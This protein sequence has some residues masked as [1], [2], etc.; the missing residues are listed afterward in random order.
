MGY[1]I[2]FYLLLGLFLICTSC[3]T[4]Q[5]QVLFQQKNALSDSSYQN[6][7]TVAEYKIKAQDVLQVRNLQDT[8]L[9]VNNNPSPALNTSVL[10]SGA[11]STSEQDFKVDDD[12]TVILPAIG[13]IKVAGYT[14]IEAQKLVEEAY[15]KNVLVNPIIE[16]KIVSLKVT[17]LGEIRGQGNFPLIKDH[18]SLIEMIGAAGGITEK[19]DETNIKI[20]RGTKKNPKVIV[21]DL[22]NI[23]SVNDPKTILQNGDIIYIAQNK[24]ATRNDNYQSFTTTI[25]QPALLLFNTA[26]I[27]FTLI[28]H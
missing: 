26:L 25:F 6:T 3:S 4:R 20:I 17:M 8:K 12:G 10:A 9:L 5:Y 11:A 28:R 2:Y 13:R 23:Q 18:T 1:K 22:G 14:R 24:R 21:V 27:I 16:L 15:R 19:A 7:D